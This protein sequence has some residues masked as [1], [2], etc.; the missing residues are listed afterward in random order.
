MRPYDFKKNPGIVEKTIE[1]LAE[2]PRLNEFFLEH[3]VEAETIEDAL[4]ELLTY[5]DEYVHCEG[6][7]GLSHCKQE[8]TGMQP[9]LFHHKGRIILEYHP[10]TYMRAA[11]EE[12]A[13][14]SR[15]DAL[16]MPAMVRRATLE[17]FFQKSTERRNLY[18]RILALTNQHHKGEKIRGL[19]LHGRYHVGKT[20]ALA[21]CGNRFGELGHEVVL[22]YY[23]D[24]VREL[25]SSIKTGELETR[26]ERLKTVEIL[27]LDDIGGEAF[28]AWI[29]DE[30]LG[31]ILQH[32]LLDDKPTFFTSN[33]PPQGLKEY[34]TMQDKDTEIIKAHR[35]IE[36]I[37][38]LA[39]V[40]KLTDPID[41]D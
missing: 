25:K 9:V 15:V 23:P 17:D 12:R 16:Y 35:I 19:Y 33:V 18:S 2:E 36:R 8:T 20:Y 7:R 13:A 37:T 21:A 24:L 32:R 3:D 10:C 14:F 29:R 41:K 26:I 1:E 30:I 22:A 6:C 4:N 5:R 11:S 39:S 34:L 27:M 31:P 40:F 38:N 28:S